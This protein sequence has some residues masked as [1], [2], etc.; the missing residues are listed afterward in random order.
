MTTLDYSVTNTIT[1]VYNDEVEMDKH[2]SISFRDLCGQFQANNIFGKK[3]V[4]SQHNVVTKQERRSEVRH[5]LTTSNYQIIS[6]RAQMV[7]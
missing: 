7:K 1:E 5:N 4:K 3:L 6:I 2:Q